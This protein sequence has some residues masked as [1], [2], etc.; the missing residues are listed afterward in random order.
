MYYLLVFLGGFYLSQFAN[1]LSEIPCPFSNFFL[2]CT[3]SLAF[4]WIFRHFSYLYIQTQR[5]RGH[6]GLKYDEFDAEVY[7]ATRGYYEVGIC[8]ILYVTIGYLYIIFCLLYI[9]RVELK[10]NK[11]KEA[12]QPQIAKLLLGLHHTNVIIPSHKK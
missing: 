3:L 10:G 4:C 6:T 8:T 1:F 2:F 5:L 11:K 12:D 7:A 9:K